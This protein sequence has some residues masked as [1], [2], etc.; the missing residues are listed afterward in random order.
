MIN[1]KTL[2][3]FSLILAIIYHFVFYFGLYGYPFNESLTNINGLLALASSLILIFL[4][5][6]TNWRSDLKG[7]FMLKIFDL[8]ILWIFICY[9]RSM[10][11]INGAQEWKSFLFGDIT[12]LSL[13]PPF[14]FVVGINL[15]YFSQVNMMLLIYCVLTWVFSL[16]FLHYFELQFFLLM[17]IFYII[18]TYPMQSSRNR[19]LTFII[20]V[21]IVFTSFTNRAGILRIFFSYLIIVIY[22][23]I[24][25]IKLNK[26]LINIIIFCILMSPLYFIYQGINGENIFQT[27]SKNNAQGSGQENFIADTRTDLYDEVLQ[28]MQISKTFIFGKGINGGYVSDSFETFNRTAAEVGFL[29]ILLKSGIVG[30]LLYMALFISAIFKA[31]NKSKNLFMKYLGLLLSFYVFMFFI[32]NILA[33]NLFNIIIWIVVG[34]CHSEGLR[35]L[36]DEEIRELF[37]N[38]RTLKVSE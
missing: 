24:L 8:M 7:D 35:D 11:N 23:I 4:Y 26:K 1:K 20:S 3:I 32:E 34:M 25:N 22:Y 17:P 28:D 27:F 9:F 5:I 37:L 38:G 10:L 14:F 16:F 13:F 31:L 6:A 18:V 19:I 29:Q 15:K 12:G 36:N 30:F 21:T 33:F 2:V